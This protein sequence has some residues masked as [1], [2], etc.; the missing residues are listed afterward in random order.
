[1][2]S[3]F[4]HSELRL[5]RD[6]QQAAH[7][8]TNLYNAGLTLP[9]CAT[10]YSA[11]L[12]AGATPEAAFEAARHFMLAQLPPIQPIQP[13]HCGTYDR[14][15]GRDKLDAERIDARQKAIN[16]IR[17][18]PNPFVVTGSQFDAARFANGV[19]AGNEADIAGALGAAA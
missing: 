9:G 4:D 1:M 7:V 17:L 6:R 11:A 10:A 12:F 8:S 19:A 5:Q 2:S 3:N 18:L 15:A 14:I 16:R 13:G